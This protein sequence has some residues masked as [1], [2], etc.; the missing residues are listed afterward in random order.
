MERDN[1]IDQLMD[2]F[3]NSMSYLFNEISIFEYMD[4]DDLKALAVANGIEI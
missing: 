1:L 3:E 2:T 4:T